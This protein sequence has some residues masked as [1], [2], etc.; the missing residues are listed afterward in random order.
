MAELCTRGL[1]AII[2]PPKEPI[3]LQFKDCCYNNL[4]LGSTSGIDETAH[5]LFLIFY[6][7]Q[8]S[9]TQIDY[10]L[11][12]ESGVINVNITDDTYGRFADFG[13]D[14]INPELS[15]LELD[16]NKVLINHG[17]GIYY[18]ER[19][20]TING[21]VSNVKTLYF[22]LKEFTE[23]LADKTFRWDV[24]YDGVLKH[25]NNTNL[26]GIGLQSSLRI[27]G[28]FGNRN[29]DVTDDK[30]I[31]TSDYEESLSFIQ[32]FTFKMQTNQVPDCI[33][34]ILWDEFKYAKQTWMSDFNSI[35]HTHQLR[36]VEVIYEDHQEPKYNQ[37]R[38]AILNYEWKPKY[39]NNRRSSC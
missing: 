26:R 4:A 10:Y 32:D 13:D 30:Y 19:D 3:N 20:I 35:N 38:T 15:Y 36:R 14:T 2:Q 11:K 39:K 9:N 8:F 5:E 12:D 6:Q 1:I 28:F 18:I 23:Q 24:K 21:N 31:N 34:D 37:N 16:W 22:N 7:K 27:A 25:L 17:E 33:T 29:P